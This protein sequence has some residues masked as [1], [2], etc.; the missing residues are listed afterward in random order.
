MILDEGAGHVNVARQA[1]PLSGIGEDLARTADGIANLALP[2][3][4]PHGAHQANPGEGDHLGEHPNLD[5][6][7]FLDHLDLRILG[8]LSRVLFLLSIV[9]VDAQGSGMMLVEVLLDSSDVPSFASLGPGDQLVQGVQDLV[10]R[11]SDDGPSTLNPLVALIL[12][13]GGLEPIGAFERQKAALRVRHDALR[14]ELVPVLVQAVSEAEISGLEPHLGPESERHGRL[15]EHIDDAGKVSGTIVVL[16]H[17]RIILLPL[18][19]PLPQLNLPLVGLVAL[20]ARRRGQNW[21]GGS[22]QSTSDVVKL[23]IR[24]TGRHIGR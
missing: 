21:R 2:L 22:L 6:A 19:P 14:Q 9:V 11:L 8:R 5:G 4:A 12:R 15:L 17:Q 1:A 18:D 7:T 23:D 13:R 24:T 16:E 20:E 3:H 10:V